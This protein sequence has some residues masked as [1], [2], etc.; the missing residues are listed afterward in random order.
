MTN[1]ENKII[2]QIEWNTHPEYPTEIQGKIDNQEIF[3]IKPLSKN[4]TQVVLVSWAIKNDI[5]NCSASGKSLGV[6]LSE[7]IA[8]D[9]AEKGWFTY[10]NNLFVAS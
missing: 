3:T 2:K 1:M 8:K 9:V 5:F 7:D 6:Y 10:V 4:S